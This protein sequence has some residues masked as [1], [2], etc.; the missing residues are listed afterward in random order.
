MTSIPRHTLENSDQLSLLLLTPN[1]Q[2]F[3]SGFKIEC[4]SS[5]LIS[6][7][8]D[9]LGFL[10]VLVF[11]SRHICNVDRQHGIAVKNKMT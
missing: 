11:A 1:T 7:L 8:L 10:S 6:I 4:Y 9:S 2:Y 3:I 5:A